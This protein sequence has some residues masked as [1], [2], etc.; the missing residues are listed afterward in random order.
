[1]MDFLTQ[2]VVWLNA[3]A[4]ALGSVLLA[5]I[6]VLPGWLSATL[7]SALTGLMLL[8][9]FKYTSHQQAIKAVRND[10]KAHLLALKL[11]RESALVALRA[12]ARI[13]LGA[14]RLLALAL[15]PMLVMVVPV[16]L[17]LGQLALWY[18]A[19][20]LRVGEEAVVTMKIRSDAP[21]PLPKVLLDRDDAF[22]VTIGPVQVLSKREVCWN[23][24]ARRP[25]YHH[26]HFQVEGQTIAKE[27]AIGEDWMRVSAARP[28]WDWSEALL[29]PWEEPFGPDSPVQAIEIDYPPRFSWKICGVEP[30]LVYWFAISMLAGFCLRPFFNVSL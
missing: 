5:P 29:H 10:I 11:F 23:I 21:A 2:I 26:L 20:P 15:V 28:A 3:L 24:K 25:G 22:E 14:A 17:L 16:C 7:V 9:V 8:V 1:M 30:W 19:R 27:L 18:Q 13:F 4:N 6:G 12:Q